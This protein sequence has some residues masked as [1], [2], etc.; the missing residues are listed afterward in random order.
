MTRSLGSLK[1]PAWGEPTGCIMMVGDELGLETSR[2]YLW[3][4][5]DLEAVSA[6][7]P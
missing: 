5:G 6:V 1:T 2:R 4:I 3:R 7:P